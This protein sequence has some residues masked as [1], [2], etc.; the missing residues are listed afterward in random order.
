MTIAGR[1]FRSF[2]CYMM[3]GL[4]VMPVGFAEAADGEK[5]AG[6]G[7]VDLSGM[8]IGAVRDPLKYRIVSFHRRRADKALIERAHQ[9]GFN[10]VMIQIEGWTPEGFQDFADRN[11]KEQYV[12]FCHDRG[13]ELTI[14]T[15][16]LSAIP[17]EGEEG[18]LGPVEVGNE[19]LW[20]YLEDRYDWLFGELLPDIDGIVLTVVETQIRATDTELMLKLVGLLQRKCDQYDKKLI[21]RTFT[22]HPEELEGVLGCV[23]QM[24]E[25]S[26]IMS[27][28][29]PQ[30][31]QMRGI[32]HKAIGNVGNHE[33]IV[34]Y[35]IAGEYFLL[36]RV[37]NCMVDKLKHHF[38]YGIKQDVE[39]I[40]VRVDRWEADVLH[41]PHEVNLWG[42]GLWASG[43]TDSKDDA[44]NAWAT[45]RYGEQAAPDVI[46]AL[47][48]TQFVVT[49]LLNVGSFTFGNGR[50]FPP[51]VDG[52]RSAF[53]TNWANWRWDEDYVEEY[54]KARTGDPEYVSD[55]KKYKLR[56]ERLA[57]QSLVE[58]KD[59]KGKLPE[60]EY[61]ILHT[62]LW[63]NQVQLQ[64]RAPMMLA[65][66][67][68]Q[69]IEN[70]DN[71]A[72]KARL[73]TEIRN[74]LREI[75]E[76]GTADFPEVREVQHLGR[77]FKI[78]A[79]LH[80]EQDKIMEWAAKMEIFLKEKGL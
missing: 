35:D 66:L 7:P 60:I 54:N 17:E 41:E 38:D 75:R 2:V 51:H 15:H 32:H 30:D 80:V 5:G 14:W 27:K 56:A 13:M 22:W 64:F 49:E 62:K 70:T 71:E 33:E 23:K 4:F 76:V 12:K 8:P 50:D 11:A 34:E 53:H 36:D 29:V 25:G 78:G 65:Y 69:R 3:L 63:T 37:A 19:K 16:E 55:I 26:I 1:A 59:V 52:R 20:N 31:W 46:E 79:P 68:Y 61:D 6:L 57:A 44:W 39:G 45:Y 47:K 48:P 43:R 58:L 10:G 72:E 67:Q 40:C 77:P 28:C 18:Y 24:P 9:L 74:Y 73:A 42:L 21:V